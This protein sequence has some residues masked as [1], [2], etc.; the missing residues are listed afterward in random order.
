MA[1]EAL[2]TELGFALGIPG[3]EVSNYIAS[4]LDS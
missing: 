1:E 2:Y 4:V 3:K